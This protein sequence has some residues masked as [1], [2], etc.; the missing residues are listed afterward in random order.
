MRIRSIVI[1]LPA[2]F[3]AAQSLS[4]QDP[5]PVGTGNAVPAPVVSAPVVIGKG[6][7]EV[8]GQPGVIQDKHA[9]G[10]LPNYRTAEGSVPYS[11]I[12]IK[13]KFTIANDDTLDGPSFALAA[14][15]SGLGQIENSNASFGQGV[16]GYAHRYFTGLADQ[17]VG[18]YM[19][20]ATIPSL[21]HQDPR[22]FRLGHGSIMKRT[23][24]AISRSFVARDNSGR[25]NFNYSEWLGNGIDASIGNLYYP[26]NRGFVPTYQRWFTQVGTDSI[27]QV[28]KEFWPDVK[29]R[30]FHKGDGSVPV[31]GDLKSAGTK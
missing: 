15:F 26:D 28:L 16:K 24:W 3:L 1:L 9:F 17:I 11:P 22:Y 27:S 25:W 21:L 2:L 19:T 20:E 31:P 29:H 23:A 13:Q 30:F 10:V 18:N 4:A 6:Q 12:T 5:P 7:Q 8:P 14:F